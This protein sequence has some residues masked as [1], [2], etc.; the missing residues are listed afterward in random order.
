MIPYKNLISNIEFKSPASSSAL[1]SVSCEENPSKD[2]KNTEII[3]IEFNY[4]PYWTTI[5]EYDL[6][7]IIK[8]LNELRSAE[9]GYILSLKKAALDFA[10]QFLVNKN[11]ADSNLTDATKI[12]AKIDEI[13][14]T[15][16]VQKSDLSNLNTQITNKSKEYDNQ[17]TAY[18]TAK[19]TQDSLNS[20]I[21]TT[22]NSIETSQKNLDQYTAELNNA[23]TSKDGYE[24]KATTAL[25]SF[26]TSY[27]EI[28]EEAAEQQPTVKAAKDMLTWP[29]PSGKTA[30]TQVTA[31]MNNLKSVY[32]YPS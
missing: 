17:N 32:P 21:A 9:Q 16:L 6:N 15:I 23:K 30:N 10:N 29:L 24:T 5:T 1:I 22:K 27:D 20:D 8:V 28:Y 4:D 25:N 19:T 26:N 11:L 3:A 31:I 2:V 12:Q 18:L 14:A 7:D 13:N